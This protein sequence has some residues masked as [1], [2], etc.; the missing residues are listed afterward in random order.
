MFGLNGDVRKI[1]QAVD[2][3]L[4]EKF[5]GAPLDERVILVAL[6]LMIALALPSAWSFAESGKWRDA[7]PVA[8]GLGAVFVIT[9]LFMTRIS[10]FL[11]F[12]F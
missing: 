1:P 4:P 2:W 6:F 8:V 5:L 9:V 3:D 7:K 11:Y 10:E 12:Q